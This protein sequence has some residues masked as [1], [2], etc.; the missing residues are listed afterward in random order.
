VRQAQTTRS[1]PQ[2]T[3]I[4]DPNQKPEQPVPPTHQHHLELG[5]SKPPAIKVGI[6]CQ[7]LIASESLRE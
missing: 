1:Q 7:F 3:S 6:L 5:Y 2:L 4:F